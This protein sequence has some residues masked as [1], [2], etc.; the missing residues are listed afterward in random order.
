[1]TEWVIEQLDRTH[2]RAAFGCGQPSLDTFIHSLAGQYAKR[3]VGHTYVAIRP[4]H[5]RVAGYYTLTAGAVTFEA[6]PAK[7]R[8]KLPRHPVPVILLGRLAV[9]QTIQGQGLGALLLRSALDRCL[10]VSGQLGVYAVEVHAID[11]RA[12]AFYEKYG[13]V[14]LLDHPLHLYLPIATIEKSST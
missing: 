2:D 12:Q 4:G 10:D 7:A 3:R 5:K 11:D 13:F 8:E 1:M 14:T 9:D 6:I